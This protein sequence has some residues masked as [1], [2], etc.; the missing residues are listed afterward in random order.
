MGCRAARASFQ[1]GCPFWD[2]WNEQ[3]AGKAGVRGAEGRGMG[4][5]GRAQPAPARLPDP[6][7]A[8]PRPAP[9]VPPAPPACGDYLGTDR[10]QAQ[11]RYKGS[12]LLSRLI[13][14]PPPRLCTCTV[15][16][17]AVPAIQARQRGTRKVRGVTAVAHVDAPDFC[18]ERGTSRQL[19]AKLESSCLWS[20]TICTGLR[21]RR[22]LT[23]GDGTLPR[24]VTHSC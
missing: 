14:S 17:I 6:A 18:D 20:E 3:V 16:L 9:P 1:A 5:D 2:D 7:M 11:E 23:A 22:A 15:E 12:L 21:R 10:H 19:G 13:L 24:A 4:S 8:C